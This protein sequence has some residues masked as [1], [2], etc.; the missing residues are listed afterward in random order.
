MRHF[1]PTAI[2]LAALALAGCAKAPLAALSAT[3][4][5]APEAAERTL[6]AV[7]GRQALGSIAER[8]ATVVRDVR[9][10]RHAEQA[11]DVY[12]TRERGARR[13]VVVWVHGGGW[14]LGDK[15]N[16][17]EAKRAYFKALGCV[18]V[19]VNYRLAD[20]ALPVGRRPMH[21]DQIRDVCAAIGWV[22]RNIAVHG[23]DPGSIVLM[24]HSA[25]GHLVS[26]AGTH[27]RYLAEAVGREGLGALKGVIS[28]DTACYDLTTPQGP[29]VEAMVVNAFGTERAVRRDASPL[30]QVASGRQTPPFLVFVQGSASRVAEARAFHNATR[31]ADP[32]QGGDRLEVVPGY[33]HMAI[34][35]A[36]GQPGETKVTPTITAFL[37]GVFGR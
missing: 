14:R 15:A 27:P 2:A 34:N 25:G 24:G 28:V 10:G 32:R 29:K 3:A 22:K 17:L 20:P 23:G 26:L 8:Q 21:P 37:R 7:P 1:L 4:L 16:R 11:L 36:I 9:Y 18:L 13:P 12:G 33:N 31:R 6:L 30:F 19:S 35:N 5:P